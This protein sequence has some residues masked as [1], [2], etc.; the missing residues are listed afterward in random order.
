MGMQTN[1]QKVKSKVKPSTFVRP[2]EKNLAAKT[3]KF[4]LLALPFILLPNAFAQ[5]DSETVYKETFSFTLSDIEFNDDASVKGTAFTET[6]IAQYQGKTVGL[7][8]LQNIENQISA[9]YAQALNMKQVQIIVQLPQGNNDIVKINIHEP[10]KRIQKEVVQ[11]P[12]IEAVA[13]SGNI[14]LEANSILSIAN[15]YTQKPYSLVNGLNLRKELKNLY[16]ENG[17][18]ATIS[19]PEFDQITGDLYIHIEEG[20]VETLLEHPTEISST[21]V[22]P[23]APPKQSKPVKPLSKQTASHEVSK[24]VFLFKPAPKNWVEPT[25][26]TNPTKV[27]TA[28][29]KAKAEKKVKAAP[30]SVSKPVN[31]PKESSVITTTSTQDVNIAPKTIINALPQAYEPETEFK[32]T[33][34]GFTLTNRSDDD[35]LILELVVDGQARS[36]SIDAYYDYM[37][38]ELFIPLGSL[39]QSLNFPITVDSKQGTLNGYFLN[40]N[41]TFSLNAQTKEIKIQGKII[42][43]PKSGLEFSN[44]EIYATPENIQAWFPLELNLIYAEQRLEV[45]SLTELPFQA[46]AKRRNIWE[47]LKNNARTPHIDAPKHVIE[48]KLISK[49]HLYG[50][51]NV[52]ATKDTNDD[53]T[54]IA[55]LNMQA[56][57]DVLQMTGHINANINKDIHDNVEVEEVKATLTQVDSAGN[58]LGFMNATQFELGDVNF[59]TQPLLNTQ[60]SGRG[61]FITNK[62]INAIRDP[63]NFSLTGNAPAGWDVEIYQNDLIL[64]FQTVDTNGEY[65]FTALPLRRGENQFTVKIYGPNGETREYTETYYLGSGTLKQ[66]E[67]NY[68]LIATESSSNLFENDETSKDDG[69]ASISAEYGVFKNFSILTGAFSGDIYGEEQTAFTTGVRTALWNTDIQADYITQ[70]NEANA[71]QLNLRRNLSPTADISLNY[72]AYDGYLQADNPTKSSYGI[73]LNK[74]FM[75]EYMPNIQAQLSVDQEELLTG[76]NR[77]VIQNQL[78]T[79]LSGFHLTN[80]LNTTLRENV[81]PTYTG[82]FSVSYKPLNDYDLRARTNYRITE[83]EAK[84][85]QFTFGLNGRLN[86]TTTIRGDLTQTF[87]KG[88]DT[89]ALNSQVSWRLNKIDLGFN[90]GSD[91][92]GNMNASINLSTHLLPENDS[93][94]FKNSQN[95]GYGGVQATLKAFIDENNNNSYDAGEQTLEDILFQYKKRGRITRTNEK[96]IAT[97][98]GLTPYA[99]NIVSVD[100][101][102]VKD[103]YIKPVNENINIVGK[104][105]QS[106]YIDFPMQYLGEVTGNIEYVEGNTRQPMSG[107]LLTITNQEG[108]VISESVSEFDGYYIFT[109]VP[110]GT[111]HIKPLLNSELKEDTLPIK[112]IEIKITKNQPYI[113]VPTLQITAKEQ[114]ATQVMDDALLNMQNEAMELQKPLTE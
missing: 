19:I 2:Y 29:T 111:Y 71:Y 17:I 101:L 98:N 56:T 45:T 88:L 34:L 38:D 94:T 96:G 3:A 107:L 80:E 109:E 41:N 105:Y 43:Y 18:S 13:F 28:T 86:E 102:S 84:I 79:K 7:K 39:S 90:L 32:E 103:I 62:S 68:D 50:A 36:H 40:P 48:R 11:G 95:A 113:D 52:G 91:D 93:Y 30:Q 15:A 66:G 110:T 67:F 24:N 99:D 33:G 108:E 76:E 78:G 73:T 57:A 31:Q 1:K 58:L 85:N 100:L 35:L 49:P 12:N 81:D 55:N 54:N 23:P 114:T 47:N 69:L 53:I 97:I 26:L 89:T 42:D 5:T 60:S 9:F 83:D 44:H 6:L 74:N 65:S 64:D 14:T 75:F 104:P 72:K 112:P 16:A 61:L 21:D 70:S 63:D 37:T 46:F 59:Q 22:T 92:Q 20:F 51:L 4:S 8:D 25:W 87:N 106:G 77:T 10:N 82:T 27:K